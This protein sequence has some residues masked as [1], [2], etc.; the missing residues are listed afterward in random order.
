MPLNHPKQR[1]AVSFVIDE[2]PVFSYAGWHL[3]NSLL[4][5][6][7]VIPSDIHVQ[8]LAEV[9]ENVLEIFRKLGC[10]VHRLTRFGDGK[11]CNKLAQWENLAG[12]DADH[13]LFL[14][15]D[16][17]C[18]S[19][20]SGSLPSTAIAGKVVDMANP[21]LELLDRLFSDAGFEDRP[22]VIKVE[23]NEDLTYLG[24]CN[25]GA[26]SVPRQFAGS[27]FESWRRHASWLLENIEPLSKAGKENHVDQISFCMALHE[28]GLPFENMDSNLNYYVHF[29]GDHSYRD[30]EKPLAL[31]HY[32]NRS[33]NVVG[34]LEPAGVATND[35]T[36]AIRQANDL[37]RANFNNRLFWDFR[38]RHFPERGSGVG[39]R[40]ANLAYK[41]DLLRAE[42]IENATSVLDVGSGDLEVVKSLDIKRYTGIDRSIEALDRAARARPDWQFLLAPADHVGP[43]EMVLCFEVAI[44]QETRESYLELISFL[45]RKTEKTLIISGYDEYAEH[46]RSNHMLF[47][48]EPLLES[49]RATDSFRS[50]R[51]IGA[52][53]DVVIYRCDVMH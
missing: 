27:L 49:L 47:F 51:N 31:L 9:S 46:I 18:I 50:I 26:Y 21:S 24:N 32:H 1:L 34:I 6:S 14:D 42:N 20:F 11:F 8:F 41:R 4:T 33:L 3:A 43:S 36:R 15:T 5:N 48:H 39:S 28:T 25:G 40:D 44:H 29:K 30:L 2:N 53:S 16:M 10:S 7:P 35:E 45:A 12:E 19:D 38:Y 22:P 17:I 13:F 23:A 52:H 37:I